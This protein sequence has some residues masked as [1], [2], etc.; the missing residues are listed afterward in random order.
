MWIYIHFVFYLLFGASYIRLT[1]GGFCSSLKSTHPRCESK[2]VESTQEKLVCNGG[3]LKKYQSNSR[4]LWGLVLCHLQGPNFNPT[5][6]SHF[7]QLHKFVLI[8]SNITHFASP[9]P[10]LHSL[11]VLNLTRLQLRSLE[12]NTFGGLNGLK[13]LDLSFNKLAHFGRY[14]VEF[15]P[16][17][18]Q[19]HLKGIYWKCD[20]K[21][22]WLT[23]KKNNSLGRKVVDSTYMICGR[24]L[25]PGKPVLSIMTF[26]DN[27]ENDCRK[28][29]LCQC[30]LDNVVW[31]PEREYL[32]PLITVNCAKLGL[33]TM[34]KTLPTN[35]TTLILSGNEI[36]DLTPLTSN[37]VYLGVS[38]VYLDDNDIADVDMLEAADWL[39]NFR[40]LSL[41]Y[42]KI[43]TLPSYA[44]DNAF[45]RNTHVVNVFFGNNP[46]VCDCHFTP[47]FKELLL[48]Y[49]VL[50]K[51]IADIR[52]TPK[53]ND[54]N[55]QK[56]INFCFADN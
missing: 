15:L 14:L 44:F 16:N 27:L 50:I 47:G 6:L 48:K 9:F 25:Y 29:D 19:L 45:Q 28:L 35:I 24:E 7:P 40:V 56:M 38:D 42:N 32:I 5:V 10:H 53:E 11:Q 51:D 37:P 23:S 43:S 49:N 8:N 21:L 52:C 3:M 26:L 4:E 13:I 33:K 54:E 1:F 55:S 34:P 31:S 39:Y 20:N 18:Q 22:R 17:L 41:K 2:F 30:T 12:V 46:W 36:S